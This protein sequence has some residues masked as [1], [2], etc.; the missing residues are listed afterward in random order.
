MLSFVQNLYKICTKNNVPLPKNSESPNALRAWIKGIYWAIVSSL[1][2]RLLS[3]PAQRVIFWRLTEQQPKTRLIVKWKKYK[4]FDQLAPKLCKKSKRMSYH[5]YRSLIYGLL[6]SYQRGSGNTTYAKKTYPTILSKLNKNEFGLNFSQ[7][8]NLAI[9][10]LIRPLDQQM[11]TVC[12]GNF[13]S[14]CQFFFKTI[15]TPYFTRLDRL[16]Q[17]RAKFGIENSRKWT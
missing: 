12:Q 3:S 10:K 15:I 7:I 5:A 8:I 1:S 16:S 9:A 2:V 14:S 4:V 13:S 17:F 11:V 6:K